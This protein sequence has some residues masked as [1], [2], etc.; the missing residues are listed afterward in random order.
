MHRALVLLLLVCV[1]GC[2]KPTAAGVCAELER[3]GVAKGCRQNVP[4]G[5]NRRA[6]EEFNFDLV[7]GKTGHVM[8]FEKANDY[9]AT[10][11]GYEAVAFAAG[12]HR[13][14]SPNARIFV[15]LDSET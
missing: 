9:E 15:H 13:Y 4:Q 5:L 1:W 3:S 6:K 11:N 10:V 2:S 8:S 7:S 12:S 14:G